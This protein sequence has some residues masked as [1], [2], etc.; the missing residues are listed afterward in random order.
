MIITKMLDEIKKLKNLAN[1]TVNIPLHYMLFMVSVFL[2]WQTKYIELINMSHWVPRNIKGILVGLSK[3]VYS[4]LFTIAYVIVGISLL[5]YLL[6]QCTAFFQKVLPDDIRYSNSI[7]IWN[8]YSA[9]RRMFK[10]ILDLGTEYF[11]YYFA[12]NVL[13]NVHH[14]VDN[15]FSL[16]YT[17][18]NDLIK[19]G[20]LSEKTLTMIQMLFCIN[21]ICL[22]YYLVRALFVVR[23]EQTEQNIYG[24][25]ISS[26][27]RINSS[28]KK[29][30]L[31]EEFETV[32]LKKKYVQ[33]PLFLLA[34][35]KI[36][37]SVYE[38]NRV[39]DKEYR[40]INEVTKLHRNYEILNKSN[41]I[42]E[43][44]YQFDNLGNK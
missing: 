43:I 8:E 12:I 17:V 16:D 25:E 7:I 28:T 11:T 10:M 27:I 4:N 24:K 35:V 14:F 42:S 39:D 26:Y 31:E 21:I 36:S 9:I 19:S 6:A 5:I 34:T 3:L 29:N 22:I 37:E 18:N 44:I 33:P 38:E 13:F 30:S 15:F 32:I 1:N 40:R 2:M 23:T 20:Y 41:D